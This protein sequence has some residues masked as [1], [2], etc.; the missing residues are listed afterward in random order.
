MVGQVMDSDPGQPHMLRD[1][2]DALPTHGNG[3]VGG[4]GICLSKLDIRAVYI[5]RNVRLPGASIYP[6]VRWSLGKEQANSGEERT[7][8]REQSDLSRSTV[9]HRGPTKVW[10]ST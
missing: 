10:M 2:A 9:I 1:I 6:W 8:S 4:R 5:E 7:V 3:K